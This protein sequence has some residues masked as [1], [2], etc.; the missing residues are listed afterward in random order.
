MRL[1]PWDQAPSVTRPG[2]ALS[3]DASGSTISRRV[4]D[5]VVVAAQQGKVGG[6]FEVVGD[7]EGQFTDELASHDDPVTSRAQGQTV[8][9]PVHRVEQAQVHPG[10]HPGRD[11]PPIT[12]SHLRQPGHR[13][14]PELAITTAPLLQLD[15]IDRR[16]Q[17]TLSL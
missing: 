2:W 11:G 17:R 10:L 4:G 1:T 7:T 6:G 5:A 9:G 13:V 14:R 8:A 3:I 15:Q 16:I 12:T